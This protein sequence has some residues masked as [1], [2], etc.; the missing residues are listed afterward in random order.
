MERFTC[1][2]N[3]LGSRCARVC[4]VD[5]VEGEELHVDALFIQRTCSPHLINSL[6]LRV[7]RRDFLFFLPLRD[8]SWGRFGDLW[9]L[10][11]QSRPV[12]ITEAVTHGAP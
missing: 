12:V 2:H 9:F 4:H 1:Q 11:G 3:S 6:Q 10:K 8:S 5:V 7:T